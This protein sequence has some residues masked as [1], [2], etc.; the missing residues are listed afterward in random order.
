MI[1]DNA[2]RLNN[3]IEEVIEFRR[4]ETG[5]KV[6]TVSNFSVNSSL[7]KITPSFVELAK[8]NQVNFSL[9]LHEDTLWSTD[10][11]CFEKIL[12]NLISN[13]F[14]YTSLNGS[15]QVKISIENEQ[16]RL[17]VYNTGKG[18]KDEDKERIFNRYSILDSIEENRIGKLSTRNGLGLA[19][20]YSMVELLEGRI[21]VESKVEQYAEFIVFLPW[22]NPTSKNDIAHEQPITI[23]SEN[24]L[25]NTVVGS[26]SKDENKYDAQPDGQKRHILVIDDNE[27]ILLLLQETLAEYRLSVARNAEEGLKFL[28]EDMPDLII[29]DIMMPGINGIELARQIKGYKHTMHI[30]LIILSAKH[31][32]DEQVEGIASGADAY[33]SKPFSLIYLKAVINRLIINQSVLKEYYNSSAGAYEFARGKL[34]SKEDKK[35]WKVLFVL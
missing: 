19:I 18:I 33:I 16:L 35:W 23:V 15:I 4:L 27:D 8:R 9:E 17:A 28:K 14:K 13:A 10:V 2:D 34:L 32:I 6:R 12:I 7:D 30:P 25:Q 21:E 24:L 31:T 20:C 22:L 11:N 1:K 26:P 29:T 3:L 5:H